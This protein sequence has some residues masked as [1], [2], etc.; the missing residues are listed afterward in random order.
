MFRMIIRSSIFA[1]VLVRQEVLPR[2]DTGCKGRRRRR[3]GTEKTA[4]GAAYLGER[5]R[6]RRSRWRWWAARRTGPPRAPRTPPAAA[7]SAAA[8]LLCFSLCPSLCCPFEVSDE[9]EQTRTADMTAAPRG[10]DD[11]A[12][13]EVE[14]HRP[15]LSVRTEMQSQRCNRAQEK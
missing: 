2:K 13:G 10:A 4:G 5:A 3:K 11:N 6:R 8:P 12:D 14:C 7:T 15:D 1:A 9:R